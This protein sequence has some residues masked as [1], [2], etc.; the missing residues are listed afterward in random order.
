MIIPLRDFRFA[1]RLMIIHRDCRVGLRPPR[2]DR[3][4]RGI[5]IEE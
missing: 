3:I 2:N 1:P 4:G 5:T